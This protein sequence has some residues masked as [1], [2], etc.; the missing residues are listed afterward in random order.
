MASD[1][2]PVMQLPPITI[3]CSHEH[4]TWP[5]TVSISARTLHAIITDVHDSLNGPQALVVVNAHGGNY[6]VSNVVQEA[7]AAG[8][9]MALFPTREDWQD[10]RA[11]AQLSSSMH[12][13]MH[14]GEIETSI[15]LHAYPEVIRPGHE[16]A[17]HVAN[18]RRHLLTEGMQ[19][20]TKNGVIGRPSLA[21]AAKSKAVLDSLT[22]SF[23]HVMNLLLKH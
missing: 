4:S 2:Y 17:D 5:G 18:E 7:N 3:S 15:L 12:E 21:T 13:D 6:V 19:A 10:A 16:N 8:R 9:A 14:A 23:A 11:A 22:A 1:A 20:Y